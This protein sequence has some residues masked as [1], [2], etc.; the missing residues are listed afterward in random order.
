[1]KDKLIHYSVGA[2]LYTPANNKDI[3]RK[4]F[5]NYFGEKFSLAFCLEDTIPDNKVK[6]AET[7]LVDTIMRL[8]E[9]KEMLHKNFYLPKLFIRVRTPSQI[10]D[11]MNRLGEARKIITG[12]NIPKFDVSN[13]KEYTDAI[14]AINEWD[15]NTYY[16][17]PIL[18]S[19][20]LVQNDNL[21]SYLNLLKTYV[22]KIEPYVLGI[23]VGGNDLS[24]LFGVRRHSFETIYDVKPVAS[25]LTDILLVFGTDY[26][27]SGAVWDYY[28]GEAWAQGLADE[29]QKDITA[30]F[31][32]KTA[33][34]PK[35]IAV[36]NEASKVLK[37]DY[38]DAKAILN[39]NDENLL[40][41]GSTLGSRMS[42][43]KTHF[44]WAEKILFMAE[45]FGVR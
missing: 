11:L 34:H 1:M 42:E 16:M 14:T 39:W 13:A 25:I 2:V 18:E 5:D 21:K 24:G 41:S 19:K 38:E 10:E 6:Q 4:L 15:E 45:Y 43:Q 9:A 3:T 33:I 12:F 35:Q 22:D 36:I 37:E 28:N 40:V 26:V 29:V 44:R 32:G 8:Y 20:P 27:V 30:G 31:V 23:R 17:M 7:I